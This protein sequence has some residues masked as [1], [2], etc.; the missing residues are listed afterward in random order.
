[1]LHGTSGSRVDDNGKAHEIQLIHPWDLAEPDSASPDASNRVKKIGIIH[2]PFHAQFPWSEKRWD[3][4]MTRMQ[5]ITDTIFIGDLNLFLTQLRQANPA[6]TLTATETYCGGYREA[7]SSTL[8]SSLAH[9][10]ITP[11]RRFTQDP[12]KCCTSF[13]SFWSAIGRQKM[14]QKWHR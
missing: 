3:F 12:E 14:R 11:V 6:A 13:T 9:R 10:L 1:M 5:A 2:A 7:L 4:V 8:S